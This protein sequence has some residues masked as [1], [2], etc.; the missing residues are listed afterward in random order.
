MRGY[1]RGFLNNRKPIQKKSKEKK[2]EKRKKK[3]GDKEKKK[4]GEKAPK[5]D[6]VNYTK[7]SGKTER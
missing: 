7:P 3:K 4:K 1:V 6:D 5:R 2:K